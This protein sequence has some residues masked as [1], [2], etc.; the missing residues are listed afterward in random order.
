MAG[1]NDFLKEAIKRTRIMW[2]DALRE[3]TAL[4]LLHV[5]AKMALFLVHQMYM[6]RNDKTRLHFVRSFAGVLR[7]RSLLV[8]PTQSVRS[9]AK[10]ST[11]IQ[12]LSAYKR[13][14]NTHRRLFAELVARSDYVDRG[15]IR[16]LAN[17]GVTIVD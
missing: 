8:R 16:A 15:D 12:D 7:P 11:K 2:R 13:K 14:L 3:G 1:G 5:P 9:V 6:S 10:A 4:Q 17:E